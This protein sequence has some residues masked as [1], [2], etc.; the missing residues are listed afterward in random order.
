MR[1][2]SA[3]AGLLGA[4][5]AALFIS[6]SAR[7]QDYPTR[8][9]TMVL[10]F[11]A[12]SGIDVTARLVADNLSTRLGQPVVVENKPGANGVVA[13]TAVAR[14]APDGYTIFMTTNSSHSAAPVPSQ[15]DPL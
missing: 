10:P 6:S 2:L 7:A 8:A 11:P 12:G 4:L 9:I 3:I 5:G 14:A 15:I 1:R 13:A